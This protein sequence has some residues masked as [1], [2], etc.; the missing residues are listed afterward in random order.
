MGL[1]KL[2]PELVMRTCS[3][4]V[5]SQTDF[6]AL[7]LTCKRTEEATRAALFRQVALSCLNIHLE[8]FF[9]IAASPHLAVQVRQVDWLVLDCNAEHAVEQI[10]V[11]LDDEVSE[12]SNSMD[13]VMSDNANE[14]AETPTGI[15]VDSVL[16]WARNELC[17]APS[18]PSTNPAQF[19]RALTDFGSRFEEAVGSM[20]HFCSLARQHMPA[21]SVAARLPEGAGKFADYPIS[22]RVLET[23]SGKTVAQ[24]EYDVFYRFLRP[25]MARDGSRVRKFE[26]D[27]RSDSLVEKRFVGFSWG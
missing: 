7:R 4:P 17:W 26:Y 9:R 22:A 16:A 13:V 27:A 6:K 2:P 19:E 8:A 10:L 18:P 5:L 14:Q 1:L 20:P 24:P 21:E 25:F 3:N 11:H 12:E 15:D 23:R